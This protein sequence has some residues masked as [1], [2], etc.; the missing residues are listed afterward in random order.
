MSLTNTIARTETYTLERFGDRIEWMVTHLQRNED[1]RARVDS[2]SDV[3]YATDE[4]FEKFA[5]DRDQIRTWQRY[6]KKSEPRAVIPYKYIEALREVFPDLSEHMA[7]C[8]TYADFEQAAFE[9][10][11]IHD[12]WTQA[13]LY[14][15]RQRADLAAIA[16]SYYRDADGTPDF[17]LVAKPEWLLT[18]PAELH[19]SSPV[20]V[21]ERA[22]APPLPPRL[23]GLNIDYF[24][25]KSRKTG[26]S[27]TDGD[28]Y[29][30]AAIEPSAEGLT[31][32]F[33]DTKYKA[34]VNSGE[35]IGVELADFAL[36]HPGRTPALADLPRRGPP[37]AIFD[38]EAR[39][40]FP[41][42]NCLLM[43]KGY[44]KAG[45]NQFYFHIRREK[46]LEAQNV[47]HVVPAGG[48][49]PW[50]VAFGNPA[51]PNLWRTVVREF[52]EELFKK[53]EAQTA[54][55]S[56]VDFLD[57]PAV[58]EQMKAFFRS[59]AAKVHLLGVGFDPVTAKPE[60]L[61][62]IVVDWQRALAHKTLG[63]R[64]EIDE[65]YEGDAIAQDLSKTALQDIL[66]HPP[67]G[68]AW[69]PAGRACIE[70]AI[71]HYEIL[72]GPST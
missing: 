55:K 23:D 25:F 1:L 29:R 60:V 7:T 22:P 62:A 48:H 18:T 70:L 19:E 49:Q 32:S 26:G 20:P 34:Y 24:E 68:K 16:K 15:A 4:V 43:L 12:R 67:E 6:C 69:L 14:M 31:F 28:S 11:E 17:P 72:M 30:I 63:A 59:R 3:Y 33:R 37:A 53:A 58:R 13:K 46:T 66:D 5:R 47:L 27:L 57:L 39:P 56:G 21:F 54:R 2:I 35:L 51:E 71:R 61:V 64:L 44:P 36:S 40:A 8:E 50:A 10:T 45:R 9:L 38:L 52:C 41:G 42:V 65:N